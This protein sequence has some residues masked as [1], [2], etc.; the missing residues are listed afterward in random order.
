MRLGGPLSRLWQNKRYR[1]GVIAQFFNVGGQTC[2][3]TFTVIYAQDVVGVP[4]E[5]AGWWLQ[6]SMILFLVSRF[7]MTGLLTI[8]RPTKLLFVMA[9]FGVACALTAMFSLNVLGLVA[10]VAIS[11]ALSLMFPTIYGVALEG[12]GEDTKFGAAGLVMAIL[13]GA[14]MPLFHA[15]IMDHSSAAMG[16][17]VPAVCLSVVALY[18]LYDLK[19][20][21]SKGSDSAVTSTQEAL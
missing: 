21:P 15:A 16:Y 12:L 8:F 7:V 10:V 2:V 17:F 1:Y 14:I 4:P 3:W 5:H 13:G 18:A 19:I 20:A 9:A 6:A 11:A